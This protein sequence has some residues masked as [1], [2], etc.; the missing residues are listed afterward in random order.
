LLAL[1]QV[2][3]DEGAQIAEYLNWYSPLTNDETSTL[4]ISDS[5]HGSVRD[6]VYARSGGNV[7]VKQITPD[8]NC[9]FSAVAF[10]L[11]GSEDLHLQLRYLV[12]NYMKDPEN[13]QF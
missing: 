8:G 4:H 2:T 12:H 9:L 3:L 5:A 6:F 11:F 10:Q 1:Q 13:R 7:N